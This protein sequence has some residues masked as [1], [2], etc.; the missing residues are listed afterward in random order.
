MFGAEPFY[1][2]EVESGPAYIG[3]IDEVWDDGP[4]FSGDNPTMSG[5]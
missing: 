4:T 3:A 2:M 5:P 1:G